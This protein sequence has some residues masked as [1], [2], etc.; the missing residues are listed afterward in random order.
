[1]E[2][3]GARNKSVN[4]RASKKRVSNKRVSNKRVSKKRVS[5]KRVSKKRVS[6]KRVT[7][8]K[9][10]GCVEQ[11]TKKYT[12]RPAP[13]YPANECC[14]SVKTGNDGR[15]YISTPNKNGICTWKRY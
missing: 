3:F 12:S 1:M 5:N 6:K 7:S 11:F 2:Y 14:Y 9:R 8:P 10:R 15:R 4:K 13:P